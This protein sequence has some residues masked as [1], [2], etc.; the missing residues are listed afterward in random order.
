M[1]SQS[2]RRILI[3]SESRSRQ[4]RIITVRSGVFFSSFYILID[5]DRIQIGMV[6]LHLAVDSPSSQ[7]R[8]STIAALESSSS[9]QPQLVSRVVRE[10]LTASLS[11]EKPSSAKAAVI[12]EDENEKPTHKQTRLA[13][14]LTSVGSIGDDVDL[15]IRENLMAELVILGHHPIICRSQATLSCMLAHLDCF[16][17]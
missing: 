12:S 8:R 11:R 4:E 6:L 14:F 13:A 15:T 5:R 7:I 16:R 17:W 1:A 2:L 10:S 9:I 3:V